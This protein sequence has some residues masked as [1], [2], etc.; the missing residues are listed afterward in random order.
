MVELVCF[1]QENVRKVLLSYFNW[2]E[3]KKYFL[4]YSSL[5]VQYVQHSEIRGQSPTIIYKFWEFAIQIYMEDSLKLEIQ[6][7]CFTSLALYYV[8][9]IKKKTFF[10]IC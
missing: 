4:M 1:L 5:Q 6:L 2:K 3:H 9:Y 10:F 8:L 7:R